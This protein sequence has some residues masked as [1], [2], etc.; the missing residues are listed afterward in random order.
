M[1]H[2]CFRLDLLVTQGHDSG[3]QQEAFWI[4]NVAKN[5]N[6]PFWLTNRSILPKMVYY[7]FVAQ[8]PSTAT[9]AGATFPIFVCHLLLINYVFQRLSS[10]KRRGTGWQGRSIDGNAIFVPVGRAFLHIFPILLLFPGNWPSTGR[11]KAYV[12]CMKG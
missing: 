1:G 2:G 12:L 11:H 9:C 6:S 10:K 7:E 3:V 5:Q 8:I 4:L